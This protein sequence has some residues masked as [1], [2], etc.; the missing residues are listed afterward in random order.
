MKDAMW[1]DLCKRNVIPSKNFNWLF[2]IFLLAIPYLIYFYFK[3]KKCPICGNKSF[4][5][6]KLEI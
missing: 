4:S 3:K 1:C 5:P 2:A 6:P